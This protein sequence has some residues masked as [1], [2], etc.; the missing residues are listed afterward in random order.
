M[1]VALDYLVMNQGIAKRIGKNAR[2]A[3]LDQYNW[4]LVLCS[5]FT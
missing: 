1:P 3:V 2:E 5:A 4:N